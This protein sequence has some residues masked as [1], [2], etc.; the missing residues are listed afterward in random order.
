MYSHKADY[1]LLSSLH[2]VYKGQ[3]MPSTQ[4]MLQKHYHS[5]PSQP[6]SFLHSF[7]ITGLIALTYNFL[8]QFS[9]LQVSFTLPFCLFRHYSYPLAKLKNHF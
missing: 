4:N 6:Y 1:D 2:E 7:Y 8:V 5:F 3:T 9:A